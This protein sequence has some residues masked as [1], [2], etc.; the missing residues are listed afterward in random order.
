MTPPLRHR[1]YHRR[2]RYLTGLVLLHHPHQ[3]TIMQLG[4][5]AG[6][7]RRIR[8]PGVHA[9]HRGLSN[10]PRKKGPLERRRC[11]GRHSTSR[12]DHSDRA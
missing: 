10:L 3:P 12:Q 11:H 6:D 9:H 8:I 1:P 4:A 2:G 5:G 7:E